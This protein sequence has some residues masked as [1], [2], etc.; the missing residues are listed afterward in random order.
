MVGSCITVAQSPDYKPSWDG[1][2][3][4]DFGPDLLALTAHHAAITAKHAKALAATGGGADAKAAAEA[5]LE[6]IA[7]T[8]ARALAVHL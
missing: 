7:Y 8:V 5:P 2:N 3:P 6:D 1:Q 4:S